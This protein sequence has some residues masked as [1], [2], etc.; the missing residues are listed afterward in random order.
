MKKYIILALRYAFYISTLILF[1]DH[2]TI[3]IL[4]ALLIITFLESKKYPFLILLILPFIANEYKII[5]SLS[6]LLILFMQKYIHKNRLYALFLYITIILSINIYFYILNNYSIDMLYSSLTA[7]IILSIILALYYYNKSPN[8]KA[9]SISDNIIHLTI[10][11]GYLILISVYNPL[12]I[13]YYSLFIQLSLINNLTYSFIFLLLSLVINIILKIST[14][15][16]FISYFSSSIVPL[17]IMLELN[18]KNP[19]SIY[20]IIYSILA[21]ISKMLK[22]KRVMIETNYV[23]NLFKSFNL[24]L[25]ELGLEYE[26]LKTLKALKQNHLNNIQKSYCQVCNLNTEC[27]KKLDIRYSF[28]S[29]AIAS[30]DNNIYYCPHYHQFYLDNNIEYE[31]KTIQYNALNELSLEIEYL[32][33]QSKLNANLYNKFINDLEFYGYHT[34]DINIMLNSK[35]LYFSLIIDKNKRLDIHLLTKLA[36][37]RFKE[38]IEIKK[39]KNK[40]SYII[41]FYK[42]PKSKIEYSQ[43]I[44]AKCSNFISGDNFYIKRDYNESYIFALSDGMGSGHNA[45][46]ESANALSLLKRLLDYGFSLKTTLKLLEHIYEIKCEYDSYATLDLLYINTANM[47]LNLYKM[48]STSSYII[49]NNDIKVLENKTLP[50]KLDDISSSYEIEYFKGDTILLFS[51]GISDFITTNELMMIDYSLDSEIILDE[52]ISI[53][54]KKENNELKDDAS[55]IVIKIF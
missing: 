47:K 18:F 43:K 51:D 22:N 13:L 14:Q 33:H 39:I 46:L 42:K 17:I 15:I 2:I 1:K 21:F 36:Y 20:Y 4:I 52:I 34:L 24:Y 19:I 35:T 40:N 49:H 16:A 29:N 30:E 12:P 32:Y 8:P 27:K 28:L 41:Y 50:L 31:K 37:K 11:L 25:N 55:L 6:F 54:K 23:S 53:L 10:N 38:E 3:P 7:L 45:Y 5:L 26:R 44:L 48:G 9:I